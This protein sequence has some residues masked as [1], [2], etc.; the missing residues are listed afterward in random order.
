MAWSGHSHR[1]NDQGM[2][3]ISRNKE[4]TNESPITTTG[5]TTKAVDMAPY[6]D[7]AGLFI[8]KTVLVIIDTMFK[9]MDVHIVRAAISQATINKVR[10]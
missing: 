1:M 4:V 9:W 2:T 8:G 10:A 6:I 3:D 5:T 7:Y